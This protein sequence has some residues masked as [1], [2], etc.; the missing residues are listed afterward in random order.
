DTT[1]YASVI[2]LNAFIMVL[3]NGGID[4]GQIFPNNLRNKSMFVINGGKDPLYPMA[5]VEPY[6]R[7]LMSAVNIEYHPQP[8]AGHNTAWWPNVKEIFEKFVTEHPRNPHPE[9]LT[10]ETANMDHNRAHWV[11]IDQLGLQAGDVQPKVDLNIMRGLSAYALFTRAQ[12]PGRVDLVRNGNNIEATTQGVAAFTLLLS[13]DTF[14]FSRPIKVVANG[15]TVFDG[16]VE[17]N[18][19]TLLQWAARDNDRTMLY[20]AELKIKL[21]R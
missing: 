15:R 4:D 3:A 8:E 13:P 20:G 18:L 5:T 2:P 19:K 14:D 17:R 9:R 6:V 11:V 10:W 7:H 16:P 1:P 21:A 12:Q